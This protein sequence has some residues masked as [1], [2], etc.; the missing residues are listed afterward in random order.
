MF[1]PAAQIKLAKCGSIS[2][3]KSSGTI[4]ITQTEVFALPFQ[5]T[6]RPVRIYG[7]TTK[8]ISFFL[9]NK[10]AAFLTLTGQAY[11]QETGSRSK[12]I[13]SQEKSTSMDSI[14]TD[15]SISTTVISS[16]WLIKAMK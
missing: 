10:C 8:L 7:P 6:I 4:S 1:K 9:K 5:S 14:F 12:T 2:P 3:I 13:L 16:I 15:G 11:P